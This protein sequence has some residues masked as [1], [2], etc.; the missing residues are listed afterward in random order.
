[1]IWHSHLSIGRL[2]CSRVASSRVASYPHDA[3]GTAYTTSARP[4]TGSTVLAFQRRQD[5]EGQVGFTYSRLQQYTLRRGALS[6][7][8]SLLD[9]RRLRT[10]LDQLLVQKTCSHFRLDFTSY[11]YVLVGCVEDEELELSDDMLAR[12]PS[13]ATVSLVR[14]GTDGTAVEAKGE[15]VPG[16]TV[17]AKVESEETG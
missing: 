9:H 5:C 8:R 14:F 10:A 6:M 12:L 15:T 16:E 3:P 11:H 7:L 13:R 2:V 17:P 4:N 1:M